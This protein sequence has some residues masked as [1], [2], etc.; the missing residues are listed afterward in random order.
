M[1]DPASGRRFRPVLL[2]I[3]TSLPVLIVAGLVALYLLLGYFAVGP[4]L[5]HEIPKLAQSELGSKATVREVRFDPLHLL[6]TVDDLRLQ[7]PQDKPLAG[8]SRLVVQFTP[9]SLLNW[10]WT[11]PQIRLEKPEVDVDIASDGTMN[12]DGVT[13]ALQAG[14]KNSKPS[15]T[16][17]RVIIEQLRI[18]G[19]V[20]RYADAARATPYATRL[21][22]INLAVDSLSTL[23]RD[24]GD[25]ALSLALPDQHAVLRWKGY[26][27]LNPL[28][29]GGQAT[30]SGL[31]LADAYRAVPGLQ[32]QLSVSGGSVD[33][34]LA[35]SAAL[36]ED[37]WIWGLNAVQVQASN[38]DVVS[39]GDHMKLGSLKLRDGRVNGPARTAALG[40]ITLANLQATA[41]GGSARFTQVD[42]GAS[43]VDWGARRAAVGALQVQGGEGAAG[44]ARWTVQSLET[45]AVHGDWGTGA[46]SAPGLT[47]TQAKLRGPGADGALLLDLPILRVGE[48]QA[49]TVDRTATIG[50]IDLQA[51][52]VA[53]TRLADGGID[54]LRAL[55]PPATTGAAAPE[56]AAAAPGGHAT[57]PEKP[58]HVTVAGVSAGIGTL[59]YTD[60]TPAAPLR[61]ALH[62]T[63]IR[64][65]ADLTMGAGTAVRV[66]GLT[67]QTGGLQLRSGTD[68]LA[69]WKGARLGDSTIDLPAAGAMQVRA[70]AL[71]VDAPSATVLQGHDG[72]NWV[73]ALAPAHPLPAGSGQKAGPTPDVRL[74]KLEL[75]DASVRV[76]DTTTAA[77]VR[78]DLV[79]GQLAAG[80]LSLDLRRAVP[81]D[82]KLRIRQGGSVALRGK[83][84]PDPLAA[85]L[86][87]RADRLSLLPLAPMLR[88]YVRLELGSGTATAEGTVRVVPGKGPL[89]VRYSGTARVDAFA[90]DDPLEGKPFFGW[91]ALVATG[92][93]AQTAPLTVDVAGLQAA[94][95]YGRVVINPNRT[96]NVQ[97]M[98][99]TRK[100]LDLPAAPASAAQP[101][102]APAPAPAA[103]TAGG[104]PM[105]RIDRTT[106]A[107]ADVDFTDQSIK[108]LFH[109]RIQKLGGVVNGLSDA[110]GSAAQVELDG[111]VDQYGQAKVR[112]HLQPFHATD[113]TNLALDF[114]NLDMASAS[115][116]SGKF[117]GREIE[118]GKLDAKLHYVIQH[119]QMQGSNQ[120]TITRL[121]LGKQVDSPDA[122]HLPLDL[123][124]AILEDSHG[125]IDL[126]L[127]V[128]GNL[129]N[130]QFSYGS[131]IWKAV[132]NVITKIVTAP[133]RALG[134]LFG[135]GAGGPP[136]DVRFAA[137]SAVLAPPEIEKLHRLA[138]ALQQRPRLELQVIPT[139]AADADLEALRN[140]VVRREV[141]RRLNVQVAEGEQPGPLDLGNARTRNAIRALYMDHFPTSAADA[142]RKT[143]PADAPERAFERAMLKAVVK[144]VTIAP[145]T[146]DALAKARAQAVAA[147]L[148]GAKPPLPAARV[149]VEA[150]VQRDAKTETPKAEHARPE[151]VMPLAL[152]VAA[153]TAATPAPAP[154]PAASPAASAPG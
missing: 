20:V 117:A 138:E 35:Y 95:P 57:A 50:T 69:G 85:D 135:G 61:L 154:K 47:L 148:T 100:P 12:W 31:S 34:S 51:A 27:G 32:Q 103:A 77:P 104:E 111:Q 144:T 102:P 79:K 142:L 92:I 112:G 118:S 59:Q 124:I 114:R 134:A 3:V 26:V 16:V 53:A 94:G 89:D 126:D 86:S 75:S 68:E 131:I 62:K 44:I 147:A 21:A 37:G 107:D 127:P 4:L 99:Q 106:I 90:L 119:A 149:Q 55:M 76:E 120:F 28:V 36:A 66:S 13:R 60:L 78:V 80:P 49:K 10:A 125:V 143:L 84:T 110:P 18:H 52:D 151:V 71:R 38:V 46:W 145:A 153:S 11:F 130:P 122:V 9:R 82:L 101:A 139:L 33:A 23:A 74:Q 30:L 5:R 40:G 63:Q 39:A 96:L 136:Q 25:Y 17:P 150:T 72:L 129:D 132:I 121:K 81:L 29:S 56:K 22:P 1:S 137:G 113:D 67:V 141:L 93:Q 24:R 109:V 70:G 128:S 48:V 88:P 6:L 73:R 105:L 65:G 97:Q 123:A 146:L 98:L 115:P 133:F 15:D 43:S 19:G 116:Y 42:L 140:A 7:T 152:G 2:R 83:I 41:P 45:G 91:K 54:W 14:S 64:A 8:F 58:W 87:L 108:P